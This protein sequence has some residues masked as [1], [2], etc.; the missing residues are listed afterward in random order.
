MKQK[1]LGCGENMALRLKIL[2]S[3]LVRFSAKL[4]ANGAKSVRGEI[5]L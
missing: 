4:V 3:A 5:G 2:K 1:L